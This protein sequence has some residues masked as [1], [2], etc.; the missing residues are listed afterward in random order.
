MYNN[1]YGYG[2]YKKNQ[3]NIGNPYKVKSTAPEKVETD[4]RDEDELESARRKAGKMVEKAREE[5][6]L[7]KREAELEAERILKEAKNKADAHSKEVEQSAKE[8][9]YR[10]GESVAQQHYQ[11]LLNEAEEYRNR[12]KAEYENTIRSLEHDIVM[13]AVDIAKKVV[14][15]ELKLNPDVILSLASDTI[16]SCTNRDHIIL[17]VSDADYE[18][19]VSNQDRIRASV[20]DL[21]QLE[22]RKDTSLPQGS[23]VVDTGFGVAD[24]SLDTRIE[25]IEQAFREALGEKESYE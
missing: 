14:G 5:A 15:A 24:G 17:R 6:Q 3:V 20:Q 16:R 12:S 21:G 4:V 22:I 19:A 25:L 13:L 7:I 9:G 23:C 8:A 18:F 10:H 1:S 2:V 11:D